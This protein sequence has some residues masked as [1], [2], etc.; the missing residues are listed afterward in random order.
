MRQPPMLLLLALLSSATLGQS[1]SAS[2]GFYQRWKNDLASDNCAGSSTLISSSWEIFGPGI[3][4]GTCVHYSATNNLTPHDLYGKTTC[5]NPGNFVRKY[6]T[7]AA[8][9]VAAP[10]V[11][12]GFDMAAML[13]EEYATG[14]CALHTAGDHTDVWREGTCAT[15]DA[16][17]G[18]VTSQTFTASTC[19]ASDLADSGS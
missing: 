11:S 8:C 9:T 19:S 17:V 15:T 2:Y 7:D 4:D 14:T 5:A 1:S 12:S 10:A 6:F 16:T 3:T 18:M 13:S